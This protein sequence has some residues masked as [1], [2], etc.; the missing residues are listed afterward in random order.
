M[1]DE[2]QPVKVAKTDEIPLGE[3]REFTVNGRDILICHIADGFYAIENLC[4]H[5]LAALAGGK[6]RR[7]FII[8]PLHGAR[9]NVKTG[10]CA[11]APAY[12]GID[13]IEL[14]IKDEV[15]SVIVSQKK[16]QPIG[17][18]FPSPPVV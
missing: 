13:T 7:E 8:C 14:Q 17:P 2:P 12:K 15:I 10:D 11:G 3:Y 18:G 5:A 9:F 16:L 4:S 6:L 1:T